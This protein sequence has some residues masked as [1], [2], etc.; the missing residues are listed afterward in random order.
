MSPPTLS[1]LPF[2]QGT[3]PS[4][5]NSSI[6]DIPEDRPIEFRPLY[7]LDNCGSAFRVFCTAQD[8]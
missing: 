3:D 1:R 7:G 5:L 6:T 4:G 2:F 8:W